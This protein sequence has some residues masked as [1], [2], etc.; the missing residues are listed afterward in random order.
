MEKV[1][2]LAVQKHHL[3]Q[4]LQSHWKLEAQVSEIVD[5]IL[6]DI[7]T[8]D[9][10]K[11]SKGG[12]GGM[13]SLCSRPFSSRHPLLRFRKAVILVLAVQRF[14][15]L[16]SESSCFV[17]LGGPQGDSHSPQAVSLVM[18]VNVSAQGEKKPSKRNGH[19][20]KSAKTPP[21][22]SEDELLSWLR[23]D[24]VVKLIEVLQPTVL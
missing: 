3:Q 1:H 14:M 12:R 2:Q 6:T 11:D 17:R 18:P 8:S 9:A 7:G 4:Q 22:L 13:M 21:R 16:P 23:S 24:K 5:S 10:E 15:T 19:V 20:V